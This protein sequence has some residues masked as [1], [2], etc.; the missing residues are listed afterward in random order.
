MKNLLLAVLSLTILSIPLH[1]FNRPPSTD[2]RCNLNTLEV[3][4]LPDARLLGEACRKWNFSISGFGA[5][6]STSA[7]LCCRANNTNYPYFTCFEITMPTGGSGL[8]ADVF[9]NDFGAEARKIF[10]EKNPTTLTISK[11]DA[12][13]I[14]GKQYYIKSDTYKIEENDKKEKY[15]RVTLTLEPEK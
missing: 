6:I 12:N 9:L 13:D 11:S 2:S 1:A 5:S 8:V 3:L 7:I 4:S 10:Q 15:I 14:E